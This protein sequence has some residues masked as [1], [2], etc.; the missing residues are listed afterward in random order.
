LSLLFLRWLRLLRFWLSASEDLVDLQDSKECLLSV[1][2]VLDDLHLVLKGISNKFLLELFDLILSS[3][4]FL[5]S[6]LFLSLFLCL[7]L[8]HLKGLDREQ[9]GCLIL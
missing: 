1:F 8:S 5:L 4:F 6:S 2:N 3:L 9:S 7:F